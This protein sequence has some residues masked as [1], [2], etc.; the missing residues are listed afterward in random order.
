[1]IS[2]VVLPSARRRWGD[3]AGAAERGEGAV[4]VEAVDVLAGGD[5]Q[6]AGV[7]GGDGKQLCGAWRG[8]G[9]HRREMFVEGGDLVVRVR[10]RVGRASAARAWRPA[11]ARMGARSRGAGGRRARSGRASFGA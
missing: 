11:W 9:D 3:R 2:R 4:V 7:A 6:L 5:E 8:G 1:M 10:R